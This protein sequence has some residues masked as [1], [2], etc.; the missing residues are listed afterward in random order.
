[1]IICAFVC[2]ALFRSTFF[3]SSLP[4]LGFAASRWCFMHVTRSCPR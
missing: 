2:F 4:L 3:D 1:L